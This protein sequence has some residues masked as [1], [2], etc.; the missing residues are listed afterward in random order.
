MLRRPSAFSTT[1]VTCSCASSTS[2]GATHA[3]RAS[4]PTATPP[5]VQEYRRL[6]TGVSGSLDPAEESVYVRSWPTTGEHTATA[7]GDRPKIRIDAVITLDAPEA[8]VTRSATV[9]DVSA[10]PLGKRS[11][12]LVPVSDP[13]TSTESTGLVHWRVSGSPSGSDEFEVTVNSV[14]R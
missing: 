5:T 1:N 12:M 3:R 14:E 4:P 13:E 2:K 10:V 6:P 7:V 9:W 11:T 8:S